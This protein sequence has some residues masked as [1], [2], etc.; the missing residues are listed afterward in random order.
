MLEQ[1]ILEQIRIKYGILSSNSETQ[2][3]T[4]SIGEAL[5]G[6]NMLAQ[7]LLNKGC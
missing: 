4:K 5:L 2:R 1:N 7:Q 3:A 6:Q